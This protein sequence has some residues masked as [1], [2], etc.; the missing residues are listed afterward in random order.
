MLR[1]LHD[2]SSSRIFMHEPAGVKGYFG[3]VERR[4]LRPPSTHRRLK[5]APS[6]GVQLALCRKSRRPRFPMSRVER[7]ELQQNRQKS[8]H[9]L[10]T[11]RPAASDGESNPSRTPSKAEGEVSDV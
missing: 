1:W 9:A 8:R 6:T 7:T 4:P 3:K 10:R 2:Y 11:P 5:W